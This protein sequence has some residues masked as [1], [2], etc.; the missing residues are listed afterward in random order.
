MVD[1]WGRVAPYY[2][3]L[4]LTVKWFVIYTHWKTFN[5]LDYLLMLEC[6]SVGS[7]RVWLYAINRQLGDVQTI[8]PT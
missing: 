1:F 5:Y 8:Q 7:C 3:L 2:C 6:N 4:S